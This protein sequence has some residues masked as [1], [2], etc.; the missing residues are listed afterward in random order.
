MEKI[1]YFHILSIVLVMFLLL[2]PLSS[3]SINSQTKK[4]YKH[5]A[6]YPSLVPAIKALEHSITYDWTIDTIHY[7]INVSMINQW[8]AKG[9][10][11]G[12]LTIDNYDVFVIGASARQY[13]HG[14]SSEWKKNVQKFV[15]EGG[16][17]VGICGGANEASLGVANPENII[18]Q[19]ISSGALGIV[20][21]Y[22]NDDQDEEW[23][24]LYKSSG[25][26][27]GVPLA[28]TLYTH[29][30]LAGS[31]S[32]PRVIRYEGGPGMYP[33][34]GSDPL[35]G[36][37]VCLAVYADEASVRAPLHQWVKDQGEWRIEHQIHTDIK[38]QF[39]AVATT[40]G[41]GRVVLFGP[42]PEEYTIVNGHVEEF[43][44]RT[45]Y[46]F[47]RDGYLYRW[48]DGTQESWTYNWWMVRRSIAWAAGIP[49]THLPPV[50]PT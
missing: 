25:I 7:V 42:H 31:P 30:I 21:V 36:D 41:M 43:L 44:G 10:G 13:I 16:G 9:T 3:N 8:Q 15:S 12:A 28:C 26:E 33:G 24:Y 40:Y 18:D 20:N 6:L 38:G 4:I 32:N 37:L 2:V 23:Q 14:I 34:D 49:D 11:H 39:A 47:F 19:V 27:S 5:V 29:P 45:K 48:V 22:V 1:K 17:Y 50:T 35:Y 46:T